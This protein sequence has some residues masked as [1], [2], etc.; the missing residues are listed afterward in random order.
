MTAPG[1]DRPARLLAA[2]V[3]L[4]PAARRDWG[5]AM[6]AE[7]AAIEPRPDR[8]DFARGCVRA[9]A[10]EFHLLRG[11]V[12]LV[13][14]LGA[15]GTSL[16][17]VATVDYPPL[18]A[19]LYVAVPALAAVSWGARRAGMLGPT[20]GSAAAWT[21]RT[22]GYLIA[23]GIV[24]TGWKHR[25]PATVEAVDAGSGVL[26]FAVLAAG[27]LL[28]LPIVLS[29]R[30]AATARVLTTGAGSGLAGALVWLIV[31][32]VAP[33]IPASVSAALAATGLAGVLALAANAHR[34]GTTAGGVLAVL[35]ATATTMGLIFAGVVLLASF[36]PD[37]LIPDVTPHAPPAI[38]V[39]ESRIEIVDPYVLMFVL[40]GLAAT[41]LG[42]AGVATR[43]R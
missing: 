9:A 27:F 40:S 29:R 19:I 28:A 16:A 30:S 6:Q 7:L 42:V 20:G 10:A 8:W 37:S 4:M 14:V 15:L 11:T 25:H 34:A 17:W 39:A 18:A 13:V 31:V 35:L 21:L 2:A 43:R 24:A 32:A 5:R 36:G 26:V 22:G 38:R 23:A 1:R 12:H 41:A 33:P 3:R